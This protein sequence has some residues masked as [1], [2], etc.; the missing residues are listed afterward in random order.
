MDEFIVVQYFFE[1]GIF[2]GL[3]KKCQAN[4]EILTA[5]VWTENIDE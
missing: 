1:V 3:V 2:Y 5:C 4:T